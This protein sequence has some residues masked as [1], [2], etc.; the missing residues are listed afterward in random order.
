MF[1]PPVMVMT[2]LPGEAIV[3]SQDPVGVP[4]VQ[5]SAPMLPLPPS[6]AVA[7]TP[8]VTGH[9]A[10]AALAGRATAAAIATS[11]VERAR[12]RTARRALN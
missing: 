3:T 6:Q 5:F 10:A 8:G 1:A 7:K 11:P 2:S 9:E 4:L 12:R